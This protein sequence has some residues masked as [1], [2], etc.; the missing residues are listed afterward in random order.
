MGL[1]T[2]ITSIR[3]WRGQAGINAAPNLVCRLGLDQFHLLKSLNSFVEQRLASARR[4]S[5]RPHS[6][7]HSLR[8]EPTSQLAIEH[9]ANLQRALFNTDAYYP[10]ANIID[11][12]TNNN[13][14]NDLA[15]Y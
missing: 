4:S 15:R 1:E 9:E 5:F 14:V 2:S 6:T 11:P 7:R 3:N 12:A 13:P 8:A 10:L